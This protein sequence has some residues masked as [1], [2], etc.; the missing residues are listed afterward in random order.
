VAVVPLYAF[1][2]AAVVAQFL[3]TVEIRYPLRG[4]IVAVNRE[5]KTLT[6]SHEAIPKLMPAMTMEFSVDD[7]DLAIADRTN[8]SAANWCVTARLPSEK[9]WPDDRVSTASVAAAANALRQTR[10]FAAA[11]STAKWGE[12]PGLCAVRPARR[13][14]RPPLPGPSVMLN[15]IYS[16]CP[17]ATMSRPPHRA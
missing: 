1:G 6:I 2:K 5:R 3:P 12:D 14:V 15:F 10:R 17:V 4:E 11:R 13:V 7:G 9:I 16:R 8:A